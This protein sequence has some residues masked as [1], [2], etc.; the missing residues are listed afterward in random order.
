MDLCKDLLHGLAVMFPVVPSEVLFGQNPRYLS[1][2]TW[3][4]ECHF[5]R[6]SSRTT[7]LSSYCVALLI[8]WQYWRTNKMVR[9]RDHEFVQPL[10][11]IY[12]VLCLNLAMCTFASINQHKHTHKHT[13]THTHTNKHMYT[14]TKK[15]TE[16]NP[17]GA[18]H[19]LPMNLKYES[20]KR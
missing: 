7:L 1:S 16:I 8:G 13:H 6:A 12:L 14:H 9:I 19:Q 20:P 4:V 2:G 3:P 15:S 17:N 10:L 18:L 11:V 5:E